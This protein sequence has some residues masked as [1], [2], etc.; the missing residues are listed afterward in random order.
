MS[1]DDDETP[2]L[3]LP[4]PGD[5]RLA[6]PLRPAPLVAALSEDDDGCACFALPLEQGH[7]PE[8]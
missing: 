6:P 5:R 3:R 4:R 1:S 2:K 7:S 8:C